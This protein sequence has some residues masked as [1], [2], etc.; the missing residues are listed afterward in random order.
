METAPLSQ[1]PPKNHVERLG[2]EII[3]YSIFLLI[4]YENIKNEK[5]FYLFYDRYR[6]E[7]WRISISVR[8]SGGK[9]LEIESLFVCSSIVLRQEERFKVF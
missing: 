4:Q 9:S 1:N 3:L 7:D 6:C 8:I 5:I 2:Y